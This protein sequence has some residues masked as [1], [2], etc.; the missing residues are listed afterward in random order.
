MW[1]FKADAIDQVCI[2]AIIHVGRYVH[3]ESLED[4]GD[5]APAVPAELVAAY[6]E[7]HLLPSA[8]PVV[9]TAAYKALSKLAH[10]DKGGTTRQMQRV[11]EAY[12]T[13]AKRLR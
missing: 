13:L 6:R 3:V 12:G 8:P 4:D 5:V 10:P 2:L 7:L 9:V 11:N 1:L